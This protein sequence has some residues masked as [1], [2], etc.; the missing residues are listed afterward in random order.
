MSRREIIRLIYLYLFSLVGLV[1][2][3]IGAVRITDLV[4]KTLIFK[5]ADQVVVYPEPPR[6]A[7]PPTITV[8]S[9]DKIEVK[10]PSKEEQEAVKR[11]QEIYQTY[12]TAERERQRER[13]ASNA[14]AM[15]IV[16][17]PLFGYHWR[18]IQK[19]KG[20]KSE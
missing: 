11:K 14:I 8:E 9:P 20:Y 12:Q 2:I 17:V 4:L 1:L 6:V 16:G 19:E 10:E 13:E 3:V 7:P 15:I 5:K 18:T